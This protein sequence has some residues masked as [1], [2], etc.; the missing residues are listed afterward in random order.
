MENRLIIPV[1]AIVRFTIS[2][3]AE[4]KGEPSV[5]LDGLSV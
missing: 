1:P 5:G 2:G 4:V 3:D